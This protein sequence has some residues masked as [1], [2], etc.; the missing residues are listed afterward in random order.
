MIA[1]LI[2]SLS[3]INSSNKKKKAFVILRFFLFFF[4]DSGIYVFMFIL[5]MNNVLSN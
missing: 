4:V 3:N 2:Y 1:V 5:S